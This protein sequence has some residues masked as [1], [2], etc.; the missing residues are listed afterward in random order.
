MNKDK[1]EIIKKILLDFEPEKISLV[2]RDLSI[3]LHSSLIISLIGPRKAGKTYFL[4]QIIQDLLK[5]GLKKEQIVYINFE[6]ERLLPLTKDD[7][8]LV[9]EAYFE[10]YPS[11]DKKIFFFFDE[12]QNLPFWPNFLRRISQ[13]HSIFITGSSS[14][15]L[16][17]EIATALRG[18]TLSFYLHPFSFKEF[19]RYKKITLEKNFSYHKQRFILKKLFLEY[20]NFGGLPVIFDLE[21]N[22]KIKYLQEY[23]N[24]VTYKDII[25]RYQIKNS[26]FFKELEKNLILE[27][28]NFFSLSSYFKTLKNLGFSIGKDTLFQYFSYLEEINLINTSSFFSK[29]KKS[30]LVNPKKIY[31]FDTGL[32]KA[33]SFEEEKGKLLETAV[34]NYLKQKN[35]ETYYYKK[36]NEVDIIAKKEKMIIP[37]QV[38]YS[39]KNQKTKEREIKGLINFAKNFKVNKGLIITF[40]EESEIEEKSFLIKVIP[41][42]K[43]MVKEEID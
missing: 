25:E 9:L 26:S 7:A 43:M 21:E 35:F 2:R 39:L 34:F 27:T 19:L 11:F 31:V 41:A 17:F 30:K 14:K 1:K 18:K 23:L 10:L 38:C 5:K 3:P 13:K 28:S 24:L 16:S 37:I 42:W 12:I 22:F 15:M 4:Y 20:I 8:D 6:D 32:Y 29:S 36:E 40:D 33:L